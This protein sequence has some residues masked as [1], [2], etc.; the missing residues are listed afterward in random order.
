LSELDKKLKRLR[1]RFAL[2]E[3][4]REMYEEFRQ[5]FQMERADLCEKL[6]KCQSRVSNLE[7]CVDAMIDY[8]SNLA[9]TWSLGN[10][11]EKQKLQFIAYPE[12]I[13]YNRK[14]DECRTVRK[15]DV[16]KNITDLAQVPLKN[17]NGNN[18][19]DCI[20]P[21]SVV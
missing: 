3:I 8:A 17:E 19:F 20:V 5:K 1:E 4:D 15:N 7:K 12:G 11:T 6:A 2:E 13:F 10:Y 9:T 14:N 16:F 18:T 21:V